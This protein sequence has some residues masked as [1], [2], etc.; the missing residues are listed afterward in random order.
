MTD[1]TSDSAHSMDEC[2]RTRRHAH[3]YLDGELEESLTLALLQHIKMCGDC[4]H[5]VAFESAFLRSI[6]RAS[7]GNAVPDDVREQVVRLVVEWRSRRL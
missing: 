4:D 1:K 7:G 6:G 5:R 2:E 3:Q